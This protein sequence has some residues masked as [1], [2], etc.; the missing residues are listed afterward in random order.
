MAQSPNTSIANKLNRA[1]LIPALLVGLVASIAFFYFENLRYNSALGY[2]QQ[3]LIT[4]GRQNNN[5]LANY[6]AF[7]QDQALDLTLKRMVKE[8]HLAF[9]AICDKQGKTVHQIQKASIHYRIR[10]QKLFREKITFQQ[11]PANEFLL[12]CQPIK[13]SNHTYGY[14]V[15]G[16][17]L[18]KLSQARKISIAAFAVTMLTLLTVLTFSL[19]YLIKKHILSPIANLHQAIDQLEKGDLGIQVIVSSTDELGDIARIFNK[20]SSG[21]KESIVNLHQTQ[22]KLFE[23]IEEKEEALTFL[24]KSEARYKHLLQNIPGA[25]FRR[26]PPPSWQM[27]YASDYLQKILGKETSQ[28]LLAGKISFLDL[29]HPDDRKGLLAKTKEACSKGLQIIAEYRLLLNDKQEIWIQERSRPVHNERTQK[30]LIDGILFDITKL[31]HSEAEKSHLESILK[32]AQ[33]MEA[34]GTLAGGIAHD[35]NNI[36]QGIS[37]YLELI[38]TKTR[39]DQKTAYYLEQC[40]KVLERATALISRLLAFSRKT[41]IKLAPVNLNHEIQLAV[42]LVKRTIPRMINIELNL[43]ESLKTILADS[44]QMEQIIINLL[45]NSKDALPEGGKIEIKTKNISRAGIYPLL[46]EPEEGEYVLLQIQDNGSGMDEKTLKHIFDP[47][48]TTKETG[49]GTGLGL[50]AV[51]GIVQE[52]KGYIFCQSRVG[53]GTTF[54]IFL[55]AHSES[56]PAQ[57]EIQDLSPKQ[58]S[59]RP[60]DKDAAQPT[61][62]IIDDEESIREITADILESKN[63]NTLC[64]R[65]GEQGLELLKSNKTIDLVL[66]DLNM[67][68]MGGKKT[69][70]KIKEIFPDLKVIVISGYSDHRIAQNPQEFG[71]IDFLKKPFKLNELI[72]CV[73]LQLKKSKQ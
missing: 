33:K 4:L 56:G 36:L 29:I 13:I 43:D 41:D 28:D 66:M 52:H 53:Q 19:R 1:V 46:P 72:T 61:I 54:K 39:Q 59:S 58:I 40:K 70:E 8:E 2:V 64:A 14:L 11:D 10:S 37:G 47:F 34:V 50:A 24:E 62:L 23:Q 7:Y 73:E 45:S 42:N 31:K 20:M 55:P 30:L 38:R 48:F 15:L 27:D 68:G 32:H 51:Y 60:G 21:L 17:P 18:H 16:Y 69:L 65:T 3:I 22:L 63:Y 67:P 35:F 71:A 25:I 12:F 5:Q 49:K 44:S 57:Q 9:G 6:L 26:T